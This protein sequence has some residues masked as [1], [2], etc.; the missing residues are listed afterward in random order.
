M[1]GPRPAGRL[2]NRFHHRL[3]GAEQPPGAVRTRSA[4]SDSAPTERSLGARAVNLSS[5]AS[6][7]EG[8]SGIVGQ[9]GP[10]YWDD[11]VGFPDRITNALDRR[12][13]ATEQHGRSLRPPNGRGGYGVGV[14]RG[15]A[16]EWRT[17]L[18]VSRSR[19]PKAPNGISDR[20]GS[21][22]ATDS[23]IARPFRQPGELGSLFADA[24]RRGA[25]GQLG[26]PAAPQA[27]T[28]EVDAGDE[29]R[30]MEPGTLLELPHCS[31]AG[32][33]G[34]SHQARKWAGHAE[35]SDAGHLFAPQ[36]RMV[37]CGH[38][39]AGSIT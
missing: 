39:Q 13:G 8:R 25:W 11:L 24:R 30:I 7:G 23:L 12:V 10:G 9:D 20:A 34:T 29:R 6:V 1:A 15:R 28:N 17:L 37:G 22:Q 31:G 5:T 18:P 33:S 19:S 16:A 3:V 14:R 26:A 35:G 38:S 32:H 21:C 2:P 27:R 36:G 4:S